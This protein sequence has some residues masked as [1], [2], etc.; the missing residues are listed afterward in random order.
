MS[1]VYNRFLDKGLDVFFSKDKSKLYV[2][3]AFIL[4]LI[5]RI[6]SAINTRVSADDMHFSV[7]AINFLNSGKL[8]VYDQSA[9]LWYYL[10]DIFY[11]LFGIGQIGSRFSAVLFGSFSIILIYLLTKEFFGKKA[12]L[13]AAFLLA[14]SPF[15]IKNTL[16]EM[17]NTAMFFV[18][19]GVLLFVKSL[20]SEKKLPY[21]LSGVFLG[22]GIL[23]KVYALLFAPALVFYAFYYNYNKN[24][25]DFIKKT[26]KYSFIF[27]VGAF[28]FAIPS[29]THNY[30]LYKDKGFTDLIYANA[31]G[32]GNEKATEL[33]SW[34]SGW[35]HGADWKGF[36]LGGSMHLGGL[37]M[38]SS[39]YALLLI[40]Y[41]DP[42]SFLFALFGILLCFRQKKKD[43]LV[44]SL[45]VLI[46]VFFYL[47]SRIL[48]AKHYVFL[49]YLFVPLAALGL[50]FFHDK[51]KLK[52]KFF[53]LRHL[54]LIICLFCIVFLGFKTFGTLEHFYTESSVGQMIDYK[55]EVIPDDAF[56]IADSRIY[57]GE[58]HWMFAGKNYIESSY[59]SEVAR[60]S[61]EIAGEKDRIETYFV[62]CVID[63]CGWGTIANQPE[64][65]QTAETLVE[66]FKKDSIVVKEIYDSGTSDFAFPFYSNKENL[67]FRVY[68]TEILLN[69]EALQITKLAKVW[70]L[71]PIG[72]DENIQPIFDKYTTKNSF[73]D[74]LDN[75]AHFIVYI[76]IALA[77]ISL[78]FLLKNL[79]Y[80]D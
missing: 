42:I 18:M 43:F 11:N 61:D 75:L 12:G 45:G 13:I 2:F 30:L 70:F 72:W 26:I 19:L 63:D 44:F 68:K 38:P 41:N 54:L 40:F 62:E 7:H 31:L 20:K 53:R 77:F 76:A 73:D 57:R 3:L 23:T 34:D 64:F 22:L 71:Y 27:L 58:I 49:L 80:D 46:F 21:F 47:A 60:V 67:R 66:Y 52:Y 35:G 55:N 37:K 4:G 50:A 56:V 8:V 16:S 79:R 10:T 39:I 51:I 1:E 5:L 9:S 65:N 32:I 14:F 6:I 25:T 17:D 24:K 28:I 74:L 36:F 33:Y 29:L 48:L 59:L 78:I 15:H 69:R